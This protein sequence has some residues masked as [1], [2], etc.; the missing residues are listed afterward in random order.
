MFHV[1]HREKNQNLVITGDEEHN[2]LK[3]QSKEE[4]RKENPK[5]REKMLAFLFFLCYNR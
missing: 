4:K 3:S 5:K 2:K 1:K